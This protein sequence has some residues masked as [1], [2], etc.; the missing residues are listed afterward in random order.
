MNELVMR[1]EEVEKIRRIAYGDWQTGV[2]VLRDTF[3]RRQMIAEVLLRSPDND[4]I[5]ALDF[6][7]A[8]IRNVLSI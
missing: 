5:E 8:Q 4:L 2:D 3:K 6:A 7:N 1:H